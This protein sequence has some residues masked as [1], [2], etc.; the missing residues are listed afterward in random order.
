MKACHICKFSLAPGGELQYRSF[1]S[2][3]LQVGQG[4]Q[5]WVYFIDFGS[6]WCH[7]SSQCL[8]LGNSCLFFVQREFKAETCRPSLFTSPVCTLNLR[9]WCWICRLPMIVSYSNNKNMNITWR[10]TPVLRWKDL[11][12]ALTESEGRAFGFVVFRV[13]V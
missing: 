2:Q 10:V 6:K 5:T 13:F 3:W 12:S 4:P 11:A 8:Y 1:N 9:L 7:Q